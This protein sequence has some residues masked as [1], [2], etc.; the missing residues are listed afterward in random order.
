[1]TPTERWVI[2]GFAAAIGVSLGWWLAYTI[3]WTL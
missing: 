1:M 2:Y 3:G